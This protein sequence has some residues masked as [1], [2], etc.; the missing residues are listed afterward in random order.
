MVYGVESCGTEAYHSKI[1]HHS[2][3]RRVTLNK[4]VFLSFLKFPLLF[5]SGTMLLFNIGILACDSE[6]S[7][8]VI[9]RYLGVR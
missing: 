1:A 7:W 8:H 3:H 2:I 4:R 5:L 6:V 9:V